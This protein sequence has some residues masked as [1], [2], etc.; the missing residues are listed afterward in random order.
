MVSDKK[1]EADIPDV[2]DRNYLLFLLEVND[3][4]SL[5]P[6]TIT[7]INVWTT[8][9]VFAKDLLQVLSAFAQFIEDDVLFPKE[10]VISLFSKFASL[11]LKNASTDP[12]MLLHYL[13][14]SKVVTQ[15]QFSEWG[16]LSSALITQ[17]TIGDWAYYVLVKKK[18][19]MHF[20]AI[21][22]EISVL[23]KEDV[24]ID[25]C[26]NRLIADERFILIGRGIYALKAWGHEKGSVID[27]IKN[28]LLEYK[29][30]HK[31][32]LIEKVLE[33]R[34]LQ[35]NT[36]QVAL[37]NNKDIL[38]KDKNGYITLKKID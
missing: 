2:L 17:K 33:K 32:T 11:K 28:I 7:S 36:V 3:N 29:S 24:I 18:T 4:F 23:A 31:T 27:V 25:T 30:L 6:E 8:D 14:L 35:K 19:S 38:E 15:N 9:V 16:K 37:Y 1:I 10:K 13:S 20:R 22:E 21:T 34:E 5:L 26:H 12:E